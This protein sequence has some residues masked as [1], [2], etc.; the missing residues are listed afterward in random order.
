M[1]I[2]AVYVTPFHEGGGKS[3][4]WHR[5]TVT[6]IADINTL[7]VKY[8]DYGTVGEVSLS[9][10]R[11]LHKKFASMPLQAIQ[12]R[13]YGL[14]PYMGNRAPPE[15]EDDWHWE[16]VDA[17]RKWATLTNQVPKGKLG[18]IVAKVGLVFIFRRARF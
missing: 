17:I 1:E 6:G 2:A 7:E 12:C 4:G 3:E 8:G 5:A 9:C 13:M 16:T 11:F 15:K 10:C 18:G 14:M